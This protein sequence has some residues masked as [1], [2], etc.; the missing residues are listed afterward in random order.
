MSASQASPRPP[1]S[2]GRPTAS[3]LS[4][5]IF[6]VALLIVIGFLGRITIIEGLKTETSKHQAEGLLAWLNNAHGPRTTSAYQP[7]ACI[8]TPESAR[9]WGECL[10]ALGAASGPLH[11]LRN[12]FSGEP[13]AL[14]QRCAAGDLSVAGKIVIEKITS[15]PPGSAVPFTVAPLALDERI[16]HPLTLR[17]TVCDKGGYPI[18]IG[19][20]EF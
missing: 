17:L 19:E 18:R 9:T 1:T 20:T 10:V 6:L 3:D 7:A 11:E 14:I 5:L 13:T 15:T 2:S 16:S 8:A 12:P 4:F